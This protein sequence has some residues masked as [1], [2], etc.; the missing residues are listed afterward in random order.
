MNVPPDQ[1]QF[2]ENSDDN[3]KPSAKG[4]EL[5]VVTV[6]S[7]KHLSSIEVE[8]QT[9]VYYLQERVALWVAIRSVIYGCLDAWSQLDGSRPDIFII[10]AVKVRERFTKELDQLVQAAYLNP[11]ERKA[12]A[13]VGQLAHNARRTLDICLEALFCYPT[14]KSV[15]PPVSRPIVKIDWA[16]GGLAE[17]P[18]AFPFAFEATLGIPF[19][20]KSTFYSTGKN[21]RHEITS[22]QIA[23]IYGVHAEVIDKLHLKARQQLRRSSTIGTA[24]KEMSLNFLA[25]DSGRD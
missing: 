13:R 6:F 12:V 21:D 1:L 19:T 5:V 15:G 14:Q 25:E 20:K 8:G 17:W 4:C 22:K 16:L 2:P 18:Q 23:N 3:Q 9:K 24:M 7:E 11:L 10:D